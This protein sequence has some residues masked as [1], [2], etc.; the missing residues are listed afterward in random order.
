MLLWRRGARPAEGGEALGAGRR[1][2]LALLALAPWRACW[3]WG[4]EGGVQWFYIGGGWARA[5][6]SVGGGHGGDS[7]SRSG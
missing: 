1:L 6:R 3:I 4:E 5:L 7:K 2:G